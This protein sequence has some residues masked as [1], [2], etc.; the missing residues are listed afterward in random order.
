MATSEGEE[1]SFGVLDLVAFTVPAEDNS[2]SGMGRTRTLKSW[3]M[4]KVSG[5]PVGAWA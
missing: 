4:R 1:G 3:T 2:P 5:A